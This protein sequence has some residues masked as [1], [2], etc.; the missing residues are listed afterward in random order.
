MKPADFK[1]HYYPA[2]ERV[3]AETGLAPLF[4]AAQAALESGWGDSSIGNNLFGITAGDK[5]TGRRQTVR[6]FEY[7]PDDRQGGRFKKVYSITPL[8]DG[9]FRYEVDRDFRDY[10]TLE[11]AVRDHAGD[12]L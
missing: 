2:I 7:F 6:T 8:R 9:R 3:C 12:G 10:D 4:V 5:W 11:Q 1:R